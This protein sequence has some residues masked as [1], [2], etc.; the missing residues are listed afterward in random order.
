MAQLHPDLLAL[1]QAL[2]LQFSCHCDILVP[3]AWAYHCSV[4]F[5]VCL[6]LYGVSLP[7]TWTAGK[8][9]FQGW[10]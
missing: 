8:L 6:S 2:G 1:A 5:T 9:R 10:G 7:R 4:V 3:S